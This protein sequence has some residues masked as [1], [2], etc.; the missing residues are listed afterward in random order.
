[1]PLGPHVALPVHV[2]AG[3]VYAAWTLYVMPEKTWVPGWKWPA[4]A[5]VI[6][7]GV[8]AAAL[9]LWILVRSCSWDWLF[10]PCL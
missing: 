9:L 2:P 5:G 1:M 6:V 10:S 3:T 7:G 8:I 4:V